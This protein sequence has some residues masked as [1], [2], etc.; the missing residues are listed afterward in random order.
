[1]KDRLFYKDIKE[2]ISKSYQ[3]LVNDLNKQTTYN[4]YCRQESYYGTFRQLILS[5][6]LDEEIVLLDTDFSDEEIKNLTDG[7]F[8]SAEKDVKLLTHGDITFETLK[9]ALLRKNGKWRVTLFTSGTTGIPKKVSHSLTS[10][11]RFVK[12]SQKHQNDTWG[13]AYNPTH[14]A[15]LQVFFQA[16]LNFNTIIRL[17]GVPRD[18]L[19]QLIAEDRITH[20]SAT[21][22]FYRLL[23]PSDKKLPTVRRITSGGEKFDDATMND[24]LKMFVNAQ[25]TNVYASTEAG[26]LL[27]SKGDAFTLKEGLRDFVK[28]KNNELFLHHSLMGDSENIQLQN[29]WYATGDLVA[30]IDEAP[31]TFKV[32]S[33]KNEMINVG[34]YK[35][36]PTEVEEAIRSYPNVEDAFVYA[37]QN[38]ILGNLV[39]AEVVCPKEGITEREIR[40]YLKGK[41]QEFKIPR[42]ITFVKLL[43]VTRTGKIARNKS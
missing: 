21:P 41:L 38:R 10:I 9:E 2:G 1:M 12:L 29:G 31:F 14:I 23:L 7:Y 35:V 28:V 39:C 5:L 11:T 3:D 26:S 42:M 32:I 16:F 18:E 24:L 40:T 19:L 36:N 34:G 17:F 22:T 43:N 27:A 33:R 13:F 20:I 25:F 15:G 8:S 30:V 37:K 4:K 6:V